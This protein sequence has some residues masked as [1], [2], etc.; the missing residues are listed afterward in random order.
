MRFNTPPPS[1]SLSRPAR[2]RDPTTREGRCVFVPGPRIN[3]V[4]RRGS[5]KFQPAD[6]VDPP[7]RAEK[8]RWNPARDCEQRF[9]PGPPTSFPAHGAPLFFPSS[10]RSLAPSN[11]PLN[12]LWLPHPRFSTSVCKLAQNRCRLDGIYAGLEIVFFYT[13]LSPP[14]KLGIYVRCCRLGIGKGKSIFSRVSHG[15]P[16]CWRGRSFRGKRGL[17]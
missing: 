12:F 1:P 9:A 10:S 14:P 4:L 5:R 16:G 8:A 3:R 6:E 2:A 13:S 15:N 17:W 11:P 7:G